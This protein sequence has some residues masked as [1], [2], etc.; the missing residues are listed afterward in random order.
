[1]IGV[2][3][4]PSHQVHHK[5]VEA[6]MTCMLNLTDVFELIVDALNQGALAQHQLIPET[7][8]PIFHVFTDAGKQLKPLSS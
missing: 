8:E 4:E 5:P 1:M 2:G 6:S 7:K 3:N